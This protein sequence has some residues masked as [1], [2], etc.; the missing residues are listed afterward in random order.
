M[1]NTAAKAAGFG[2]KGAR[3]ARVLL[4]ALACAIT[5][6]AAR[7]HSADALRHFGLSR[8]VPAA[9]AAVASPAE[10]RLWFTQV[11][12]PGSVSIRLIDARESAVETGEPTPDESD[13]RV[14]A[15][16]VGRALAAGAYTVAWRGIGDDGH[17]VRGEYRFTVSAE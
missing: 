1:M 8:S 9:D 15:I 17:T 11:A 16:A 13:G 12:Q 10:V 4:V 14:Y 7:G 2:S 5:L 6:G 3:G